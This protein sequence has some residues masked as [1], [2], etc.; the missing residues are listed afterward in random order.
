MKLPLGAML[1]AVATFVLFLPATN[2]EFVELDDFNYIVDNR[3]IET[4]D[5]QAVVWAFTKFHEANWHPLTMLSLMFDRYF[6]GISPFHFHL[7]NILIHSCTVFLSCI[8]FAALLKASYQ[9]ETTER[10]SQS[11]RQLIVFSSIA[12][13]LFFGLHPLRVESVVWASERKDVLCVFFAVSALWWYLRYV[14][15]L[16][17]NS[18]RSFYSFGAYWM[19]VLMTGLALLSKPTAVSLPLVLLIIDWYPLLRIKDIAGFYRALG[20]KIPLLVMAVGSSLLTVY[21]QQE[22]MLPLSHLS[23]PSRLLVACKALV[24]YIW[25]LIWP[26]ALTPYYPHPGNVVETSPWEY[27]L[28]ALGVTTFYIVLTRMAKRRQEWFAIWLYFLISLTPTLGI[29]QVGSQ[30]I[31]DRYTYFPAMG[32]ALLWGGGIGKLVHTLRKR[33]HVVTAFII[34]IILVSQLI[35][36]TFLTMRLI[37][38][39]RNT[40][41]LATRVI[42]SNPHIVGVAYYARAKYRNKTGE[43]GKALED[44]NEASSIAFR[45]G[46]ESKYAELSMTRAQVLYNL[47]RLPEALI[48]V[49]QA[50]RES[51][52]RPSLGYIDFRDLLMQ[53]L[54]E[55]ENTQKIK[56]R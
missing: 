11:R 6:W 26:V 19:V 40:E 55:L 41:T 29:I 24:F 17:K 27:L 18:D 8:L 54:V 10:T 14:N 22:S 46:L 44:I 37:P 32:I 52:T 31:A 7:T 13:A 51:A 35:F 33:G 21:A 42:E 48:A 47:G 2:N 49:N 36:Y 56:P 30:W 34:L 9:N 4:L 15:Q 39:W 45:K 53:E 5:C 28:Y 20:E 50:I 25:K 23:V 16:S 43:Y 38:V 1:A 3:H 12:S